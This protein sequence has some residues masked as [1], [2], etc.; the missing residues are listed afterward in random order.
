MKE[1]TVRKN[2][3]VWVELTER[4]YKVPS[5]NVTVRRAQVI[6][7]NYITLHCIAFH[8]SKVSQNNCR[9]WNMSC[10]YKT[11]HMYSPNRVL[12][13]EK[14]RIHSDYTQDYLKIHKLF[15][16]QFKDT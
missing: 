8:A 2:R 4:D 10:K 7:S 11:K 9:M 6:R 13:Q 12:T 1:L 14:P 5:D 16:R 15:S 3:L